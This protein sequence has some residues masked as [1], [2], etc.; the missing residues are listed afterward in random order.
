MAPLDATQRESILRRLEF[1]RLEVSDLEQFK[2]MSRSD[3]ETDRNRRRNL[4]R[5]SENLVNAMLDIAKIVLAGEPVEIPETYRE[6]LLQLGR[7]GLLD[8]GLA[9][10]IA[11][12]ARL[13]NVLAH[14]YLDIR[15]EMLTRFIKKGE[16]LTQG[17][18]EA[19]EGKMNP[20]P[21]P[22]FT[23]ERGGDGQ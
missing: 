21:P 19:M 9:E 18:V 1:I 4:E 11:E 3:Y 10:G 5:L 14:Q 6:V 12:L 8:S 13:R 16:G 20:P 7:I 22:S 17:F 15:W 23:K 2:G